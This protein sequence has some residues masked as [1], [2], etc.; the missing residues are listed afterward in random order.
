MIREDRMD[1][2][3]ARALAVRRPLD[4]IYALIHEAAK[5][6]KLSVDV[7]LG[8]ESQVY[9]LA[10]GYSTLVSKTPAWPFAD[11][12]VLPERLKAIVGDLEYNG[13]TIRIIRKA[14]PDAFGEGLHGDEI[15]SMLIT[16]AGDQR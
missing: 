1:A 2:R 6:C 7:P 16:W 12:E 8:T 10:D 9:Q 5:A 15:V 3:A 11:S 14:Q 4:Y 13:Y